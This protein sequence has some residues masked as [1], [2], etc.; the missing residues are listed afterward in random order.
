MAS[1]TAS[2][3]NVA[4]KVVHQVK[5]RDTA[6]RE[7]TS[8]TREPRSRKNRPSRVQISPPSERRPL[9]EADTVD[10]QIDGRQRKFGHIT[11][12]DL[13]SCPRCVDPSTK[14]KQ[15]Y[16][17]DIPSNITAKTVAYGPE[18]I[19]VTWEHDVP[20]YGQDHVSVY[21]IDMLR[22]LA[23]VGRTAPERPNL[24]RTLWTAAQYED[25]TH[26]F[27][28][29]SYMSDDHVLLA[30]IRQLHTHG[31]LFVKNIPED[32]ESVVRLAERI[33]PLKTTFYGKTWDVRSVPEAKNV[34]YTSQNLGFHM[35]L[36]YMKQPPHLQLLHC[37][38]SSSAGGA[39]LFS[40]SF[41][42]ADELS[43]I[44]DDAY[45]DLCEQ[46]VEFHYDHPGSN[47]YHQTRRVMEQKAVHRGSEVASSWHIAKR[48][49]KKAPPNHWTKSVTPLDFLESVAWSPPFQ[50]PFMLRTV[51]E[52][53]T[54]NGGSDKVLEL[55]NRKVK[56]WHNAA[57]KFN[58]LIHHPDAIYERLM[59]P[60][61]CVIFDNRRV[62]H[63][64][65]AFAVGDAGKERWLRGAYIDKDPYLSK[66]RVSTEQL[67]GASGESE[68][69][70]DYHEA[71][72]SLG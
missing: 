25:Q 63:A 3:G 69:R 64:R 8:T 46:S 62:L 4:R 59:R 21:P 23:L 54:E 28:Y 13:C 16:T 6:P 53:L 40:D 68:A 5:P 32:A 30:A 9:D 14:Q 72:S 60:G 20:G 36:M 11:L 1:F 44:D 41:K 47:Y 12:R 43:R 48:M 56:S 70:V 35:D 22:N 39:S 38:R 66:L 49:A 57:Q 50:A 34:A 27:D 2:S 17:P 18:T 26:D 71:M 42:A 58:E 7:A 31:L 55:L 45:I 67:E 61:E 15:V 19:S 37:I 65:R 52:K 24:P 29:G 33:G 10:I 51:S